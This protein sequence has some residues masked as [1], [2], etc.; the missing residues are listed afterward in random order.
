MTTGPQFDGTESPGDEHPLP[1]VSEEARFERLIKTLPHVNNPHLLCDTAFAA[2]ELLLRRRYDEP[3]LRAFSEVIAEIISRINFD[4]QPEEIRQGTRQ[5]ARQCI[6]VLQTAKEKRLPRSAVPEDESGNESETEDAP[7]PAHPALDENQD[8]EYWLPPHLAH[9]LRRLEYVVPDLPPP[10]ANFKDFDSLCEA[11]V[12]RRIDRI[13]VFFRRHNPTVI[14]EIPPFFLAADEFAVKF[15]DA[16]RRFIYPQFRSSRQVRLLSTSLDLS[17]T[18]A[19]TFW[20]HAPPA[21]KEKLL[22]V[23]H[24]AWD[25]L[26]LIEAKKEEG[27]NVMQVKA[28][29]KDLRDMLN[30][31]SPMAY[32]LPK[33]G[34]REIEVFKSLL[35]TSEDW[36]ARLNEEWRRFHDFYEQEKDPRMF[37]QQAREGAFRDSLLAIFES[38]PERWGDF[39]VLLCHRVF[40]HVNTEFLKSFVVNLGLTEAERRRRAPY[41]MRY[42]EQVHERPEISVRERREQAEREAEIKKLRNHLKGF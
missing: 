8:T 38:L 26:K 21:L 40:P 25:D 37:Q 9:L 30:P 42:L 12:F 24:Q 18:D 15:K 41:L 34:N 6:K 35:D 11:A 7:V 32:D 27:I 2:L 36:W 4:G 22:S 39:L 28:S 20:E 10:E 5:A 31:S 29:T 19:E 3:V 23:W 33:V 16:V 14:R 1:R 13:L 17:R